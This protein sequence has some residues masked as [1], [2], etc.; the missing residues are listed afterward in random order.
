MSA[1]TKRAA[2]RLSQRNVAKA[3]VA[4]ISIKSTKVSPRGSR[5]PD[6]LKAIAAAEAAAREIEVAAAEMRLRGEMPKDMMTTAFAHALKSKTRD[7]WR[8]FIYHQGQPLVFTGEVRASV[9][10]SLLF[11]FE[12]KPNNRHV[13]I[14]EREVTRVEVA[15]QDLDAVVKDFRE[16]F[17][18]SFGSTPEELITQ[19]AGSLSASA[20]RAA[21]DREA[22]EEVPVAMEQ[23]IPAWGRW[24]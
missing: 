10:G 14:A 12:P 16:W 13:F 11:S 4:A 18:A 17:I 22:E 21:N 19:A 20:L 9:A 24:S 8:S 1:T 3:A 15:H 7:G 5:T 6:E 2:S 23:I